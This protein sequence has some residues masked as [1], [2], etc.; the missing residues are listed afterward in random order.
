MIEQLACAGC[1]EL[2][3]LETLG[4][5]WVACTSPRGSK[6]TLSW[7]DNRG[8]LTLVRYLVRRDGMTIVGR[9]RTLGTAA[10]TA[11]TL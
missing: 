11:A 7:D 8:V 3:S 2:A 10:D 1:T 4:H 9:F 5:D 6:L